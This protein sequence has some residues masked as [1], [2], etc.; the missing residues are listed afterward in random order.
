MATVWRF[1]APKDGE[2]SFWFASDATALGPPGVPE[3]GVSFTVRGPQGRRGFIFA[4][5]KHHF[6][7]DDPNLATVSQLAIPRDGEGSF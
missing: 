7:K 4:C 2:A 1:A 5:V 6:S 3:R